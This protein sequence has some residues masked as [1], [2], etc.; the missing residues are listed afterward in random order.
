MASKNVETVRAS[1]DSWNRRDFDGI[2][3]TLADSFTYKDYARNETLNSKQHFRQWVEAWAKAFPDGKITNVKCIDGGDTVVAQFTAE[4]TNDGPFA[5]LPATGR[6]MSAAFCEI[7]QFDKNGRMTSG[8]VYY[9]QY[10]ILTQLG[11]AK[12]LGRAA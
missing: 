1:Y 11:H 2:V 4:G 7:C 6:R 12:A 10:S 8:G 5:G 9:D 3:A